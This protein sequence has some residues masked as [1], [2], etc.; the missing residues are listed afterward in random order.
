MLILISLQSTLHVGLKIFY[1]QGLAK[2]MYFMF[3]QTIQICL[4]KES[5]FSIL[6]SEVG[7][8]LMHYTGLEKL[9]EAAC[10]K[11]AGYFLKHAHSCYWISPYTEFFIQ[12]NHIQLL[13]SLNPSR[14]FPVSW[15]IKKNNSEN[16][17]EINLKWYCFVF[18]HSE[19]VTRYLE[20][21]AY[22][23]V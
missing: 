15:N 4:Y 12:T 6:A 2:S 13:S 16:M 19:N 21:N 10:N 20:A 17:V 3:L 8:N 18:Q 7:M 22:H 11:R 23:E 14:M 5:V 1:N 9:K